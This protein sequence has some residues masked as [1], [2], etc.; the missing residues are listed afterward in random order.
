MGKRENFTAERIASYKCSAAK[1]QTIFWDGKTPCLGLRVTQSG[2]KSY[3]FESRLQGKTLRLTLGS[4]EVWPL[5]TQW[6]GNK[7]N[8]ER[9]EFRR[10]A[11][12]E[13]QRLK[14]LTDQGVDPRQQKAEQRAKA[15]AAHAEEERRGLLVSEVWQSYIETRKRIWGA[16]HLADHLA[17]SQ[18]GGRKTLRGKGTTSPGPLAALMS[19]RL[20]QITRQRIEAW[21]LD[22]AARR[23]TQAALAYRLLCAFIRWCEETSD[24]RGLTSSDV[25]NT[26][27]VRD[28]LPKR[29]AKS[30][31]LQREQLEPWFAAVGSIKNKVIAAYL[32]TLL[33]TGARRRELASLKWDDV[34]FR[35]QTMTLRDK[36]DGERVIPLPPFVAELLTHLKRISDT[37][38]PR[39]RILHGK[40]IENDLTTWAPSNW[41]FSSKN[42]ASGMLQDPTQQHYKACAIA[43]IDS[44]TLHG[45]RRSFGTLSEWV[46]CPVGVVAQIMG[47][48]PSATAEKHYKVRPIDLLRLWH[49]KIEAWILQEAGIQI[50]K[51]SVNLFGV[52]T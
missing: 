24:Y 22:E 33:L 2:A 19:L 20:D 18:P 45:L 11:R 50:E 4:P 43:G 52:N 29:N 31:C 27:S 17:L 23:P 8:G 30:D 9:I 41:V 42:A 49:T 47:H 16:R 25:C 12:D 10:G 1:Q 32:Q 3:I 35:W 37:P 39:Y 5:E 13:A 46:E 15:N 36:V 14:V 48:K 40:K 6:R 21:L 28:N 26:R 51:K 44:L 38:P 7:A 34:D